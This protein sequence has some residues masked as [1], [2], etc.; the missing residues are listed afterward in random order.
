MPRPTPLYSRTLRAENPAVAKSARPATE[1]AYLT[2]L[3]LGALYRSGELSPVEVV[4]TLLE[5]IDRLNPVLTAYVTVTDDLARARAREAE[6]A[7]ARGDDRPLLGIPVSLKDLTVTKGIRTTRGSLLYKDWIPDFSSPAAD[8]VDE[9]GMVLLGKTNTPEL[10]WKGDSGNRVVGP[11]HNPWKIGKTAGG[12]SG[13]AAAAV[14]AGLGPVAQG[15]DGAGSIRIP[16]A[17]CGVFGLK[18][19][20]GLVP[21]YPSSAAG[22]LSHVGPITRTVRD[23]ALLLNG[24]AGPDSRDPYSLGATGIDYLAACEGGVRCL[25]VAWSP[26]LGSASLEPDVADLTAKAAKAFEELGASVE[27]IEWPLADPYGFTLV[28]RAT[29]HAAAFD[30]LD[31]VR[32][33][34]DPGHLKM[35]EKGYEYSGKELAHSYLERSIY[36]DQVR[37]LMEPYDL[38]LTPALPLTAYDAGL[39]RPPLIE[40]Q[41]EQLSWTPFTYPFNLTG[42]PAATVPCGFAADGLPVGLQVVGRWR[43][44]ATVLR[45][46]AAFEDLRP[47]TQVRPAEPE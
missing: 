37:K 21:Y 45:A 19:S 27:E 40:G 9:A 33:E 15:S 13:G 3:E 1:I 41:E 10:G 14:A 2:A 46:C 26:D 34:L 18:P 35:V 7:L 36:T 42:Q 44:D 31:A 12:S 32:A 11:T 24:L 38:L 17:F 43:E 25:R 4:D 16:A 22:A 39:D 20:Y 28:I 29:G 30:D 5:R 8:R 47:W 6:A 23:G